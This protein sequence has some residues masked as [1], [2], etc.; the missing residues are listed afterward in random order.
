MRAGAA[1]RGARYQ[2][3]A[4][5]AP[6]AT[7][8]APPSVPAARSRLARSPHRPPAQFAATARRICEGAVD[9]VEGVDHWR[10]RCMSASVWAT[11]SC[12][13]RVIPPHRE[14]RVGVAGVL[15]P[16]TSRRR[17]GHGRRTVRVLGVSATSASEISAPVSG[18]FDR[19]RVVHRSER[20]VVDG[21]NRL[22]DPTVTTQGQREL[23]LLVQAG[24]DHLLGAERASRRGP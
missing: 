16:R 19:A 4:R 21:L 18:C 15:D 14:Q 10:V 24:A 11:R 3:A 13:K 17:R 1:K 8:C 22:G 9:Q 20:V 23:D 6:R 5:V 12:E 7:A 2:V